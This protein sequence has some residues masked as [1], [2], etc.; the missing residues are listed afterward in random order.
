[1]QV[2]RRLISSL[3]TTWRRWFPARTAAPT[4]SQPMQ[5]KPNRESRSR[6]TMP[7]E[8]HYYLGDLLDQLDHFFSDIHILRKIDRDSYDLFSGHGC[9]ISSGHQLFYNPEVK[10][11]KNAFAE[12]DAPSFGCFFFPHSR[13]KQEREGQQEHLRFVVFSKERRPV[14]VQATNLPIYKVTCV[15]HNSKRKVSS[16][17][18]FYAAVEN[19]G[20]VRALKICSPVRQ[21]PGFVRM[22]WGYPA[23]LMWLVSETAKN[24]GA[25]TPDEWMHS[26]FSLF[27]YAATQHNCGMTVRVRKGADVAA[28]AVDMLRTPY[29]FADRDKTVTVNGHTKKIIHIVRAHERVTATGKTF[30]RSHFRG[31]RRFPWNG[32]QVSVSMAGLHHPSLLDLK[33]ASIEEIDAKGM[34][35][36]D[37]KEVGDRIRNRF[38]GVSP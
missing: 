11:M 13:K 7:G 30:V 4:V 17:N 27:S 26:L 29:F 22:Q 3:L 38:D 36:V 5:A 1:M 10:G 6:E 24:G 20:Q 19:D 23:D 37:S 16:G 8:A 32:Y 2:I 33:I 14:N 9:T 12:Y 21:A 25:T 35:V 18:C 15:W 28:F 34:K 31:E